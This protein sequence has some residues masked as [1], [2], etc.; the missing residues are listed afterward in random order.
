MLAV[1]H[2]TR[3]AILIA[4][5]NGKAS[6]EAFAERRKL[7][8]SAARYHF[9]VLHGVG[10]IEATGDEFKITERGVMLRNLA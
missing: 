2:P 4:L 3:V 8:P 7:A 6:P 10:A 5:S 1:R 9:M